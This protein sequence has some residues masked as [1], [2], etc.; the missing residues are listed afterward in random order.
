VK[1][2]TV[3][4][5]ARQWTLSWFE[6]IETLL[7]IFSELEPVISFNFEYFYINGALTI[8]HYSHF[9]K[10]FLKEKPANINRYPAK[11]KNMVS[12]YQC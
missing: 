5:I 1:A 10:P 2:F 8:Y 3:C 7:F 12:S 9:S 11:A 6:Y 4:K